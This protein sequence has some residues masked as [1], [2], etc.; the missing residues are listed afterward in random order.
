MD[1]G[2]ETGAIALDISN[3]FDKVWYARLL[4]KLNAYGVRG[5]I[6]VVLDGQS[7][8]PHDINA[9]ILQ[10]SL[11]G[12]TFFLMYIND[13]PDGVFSRIGIYADSNMQTSDFFN[14]LEMTADLEED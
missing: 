1:V 5:P 3:A 13:L 2:G 6:N 8:I 12:P 10:G 4:D 14:R 7:S 11:L 9:G